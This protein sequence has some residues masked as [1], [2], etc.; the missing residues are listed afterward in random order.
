[1]YC[2]FNMSNECLFLKKVIEL[3]T[4]LYEHPSRLE[5]KCHTDMKKR[6]DL[7][8]GNGQGLGNKCSDQESCFATIA[9]ELG[10]TQTI[11]NVPTSEYSYRYQAHGTQKAVDF[12]LMSS[13]TERR[14]P[15]DLKH[16]GEN[17]RIFLNDGRFVPG[18]IYVISFT[19][20]VKVKGRRKSDREH[21]CVIV[22]G[23]RVMTEKDRLLLEKY[24]AIIAEMNE[25][26]KDSD[27]LFLRTRSANQYVCKQFTPEFV[28]QEFTYLS[29]RLSCSP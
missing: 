13:L 7:S 25:Q 16:G 27:F 5:E 24:H 28:K 10:W 2:L 26:E 18:E 12:E 20:L 11:T 22:L 4:F 3:L 6:L 15:F 1:M 29:E 8:C 9:E 21:V 19:K 23:E 14:I 17:G